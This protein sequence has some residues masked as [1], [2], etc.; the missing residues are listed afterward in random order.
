M[1]K[2][3]TISFKNAFRGL[4]WAIKTQPNFKIHLILSFVALAASYYL[5]IS[6]GELL[7]ILT[8]IAIGLALEAVN[9]AFELTTD[10]IDVKWRE[11]IGLAKDVAAGAMLIFS[12]M[13]VAVS[14][15]IFVP[16][17]V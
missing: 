8:F 12:I 1:I 4:A 2:R 5:S 6:Y 14:L 15:I 13:A 3:H 17:I 7:I 10:A 9:T 11:D 16:K